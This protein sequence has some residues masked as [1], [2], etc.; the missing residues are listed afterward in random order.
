ME[1]SLGFVGQGE[2]SIKLLKMNGG[3]S[4][5]VKGEHFYTSLALF[6]TPTVSALCLLG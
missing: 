4:K 1:L 3:V 6:P 5:K 2:S